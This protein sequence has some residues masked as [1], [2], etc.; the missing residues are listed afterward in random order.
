MVITVR[1]FIHFYKSTTRVVCSVMF[2]YNKSTFLLTPLVRC[3]RMLSSV[4]IPLRSHK[5]AIMSIKSTTN[6]H[7]LM[8]EALVLEGMTPREVSKRFGITESRLSILRKSPLW[9]IEEKQLRDD[10]LASYRG[11]MSS[12]IPQ[13]LQAL[14]DTVAPENDPRVRLASAREILGR[15]GLGESV[16]VEHTTDPQDKTSLFD[17]LD[18]IRIEKEKL[19]KE[20]GI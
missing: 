19:M 1:I 7:R 4:N 13:A 11:R 6:K 18:K 10:H 5:G 3:D 12:L 14:E 20:L 15:G 16:S 2:L 8:M 17:T 9:V